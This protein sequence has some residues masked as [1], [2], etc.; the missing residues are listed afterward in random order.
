MEFLNIEIDEAMF[1]KLIISSFILIFVYMAFT[2]SSFLI[3]KSYT[4]GPN[5]SVNDE[6]IRTHIDSLDVEKKK[7][8]ITGWAYK[9]GD[10]IGKINSSFVIKNQET[11]KMY[12]MRT[13]AYNNHNLNG[14]GYEEAGI[15]AQCLLIGLPKGKYQIFVLYRNNDQDILADTLIPFEIK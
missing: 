8:E 10:R 4:L 6:E 3:F 5:T 9:E 12:L 11:G 13:K 14:T 7:I 2:M 15:H 1:K